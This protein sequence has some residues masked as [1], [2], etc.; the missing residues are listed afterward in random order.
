MRVFDVWHLAR[1]GREMPT[2]RSAKNRYDRAPL[3]GLD[4]NQNR[5]L[6]QEETRAATM[7]LLGHPI[8]RES[9]VRSKIAALFTSHISRYAINGSGSGREAESTAS[10]ARVP[11]SPRTVPAAEAPADTTSKKDVATIFAEVMESVGTLGQVSP[12]AAATHALQYD[13]GVP[14]HL[15]LGVQSLGSSPSG[16]GVGGIGGSVGGNGVGGGYSKAAIEI[17]S[18]LVN[19]EHGLLGQHL[20]GSLL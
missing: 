14:L 20:L 9:E 11:L 7:E 2:F 16:D 5:Y 1:C 4:P 13:S 8:K 3:E 15:S 19:F 18:Q 17:A 12:V 6:L 10:V